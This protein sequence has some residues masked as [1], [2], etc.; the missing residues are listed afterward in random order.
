MQSPTRNPTPSEHYRSVEVSKIRKYMR[1]GD[2]EFAEDWESA[3]AVAKLMARKGEHERVDHLQI[4]LDSCFQRI[5]AYL[6]NNPD[7][8]PFP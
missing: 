8:R 6:A 1:Y 7:E 4:I 2:R 5:E 3:I